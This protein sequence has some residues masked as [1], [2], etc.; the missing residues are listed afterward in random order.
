[1]PITPFH[2]PIAYF[3][4]KINK[5]LS[6]PGLIVGCMFP[7]LE[8][9]FI[10]LILGTQ[11]PN[12]MILHSLLGSVTLGTLLAVLVT[13]RVYPFLVSS[14]FHI[15]KKKVE[16]KCKLSLVLVFSVLVGNISHVLL[17]VT[18][19]PYNPIFWPFHSTISTTSPIYFA[20][21]PT[22]GSL[23]IQIIMGS[24]FAILIFIKR[25]NLFEELLVG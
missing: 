13:T 10:A 4:Y 23:W 2:H 14:L 19:H 17:D 3:I 15:D 8:I 16:N 21:G 18:N 22:L 9:P 24:L 5:R 12:R 20:L 7:D 6:L 11:G 25:K 1:M